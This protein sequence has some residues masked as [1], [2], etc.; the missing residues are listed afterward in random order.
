PAQ[1]GEG[2]E[3]GEE[4]DGG[5]YEE[6]RPFE[7]AAAA[8][9][10]QDDDMPVDKPDRGC[11]EKQRAAAHVARPVVLRVILPPGGR[12]AHA[13]GK[14]A[15]EGEARRVIAE[16][17]AEVCGGAPA[18][19]GRVADAKD[20]DAEAREDGKGPGEDD[21][22]ADAAAEMRVDGLTEAG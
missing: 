4:G 16:D 11:A 22:Q 3:G 8:A 18:R 19:A 13:G 9:Q 20:L 12:G 21:Q 14:A 6:R 10:R 17:E 15:G 2:E 1:E 7:G 5:E